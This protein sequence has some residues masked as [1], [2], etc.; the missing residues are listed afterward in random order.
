MCDE[1][2]VYKMFKVNFVIFFYFFLDW[3]KIFKDN[4]FLRVYG[5]MVGY[6]MF[7]IIGEDF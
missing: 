5:I 2:K 7:L 3:F 6:W 4:M 1:V